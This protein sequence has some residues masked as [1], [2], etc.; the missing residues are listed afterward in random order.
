MHLEN[1]WCS[2]YIASFISIPSD[3]LISLR[4]TAHPG[5]DAIPARIVH[6]FGVPCLVTLGLLHANPVDM[7]GQKFGDLLLEVVHP[8]VFE[9]GMRRLAVSS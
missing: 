3:L 1:K 8:F 6:H 9:D 5:D 7:A 4:W 2:D